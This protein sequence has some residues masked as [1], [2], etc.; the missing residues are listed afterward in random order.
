MNF[1][2]TRGY[3]THVICCNDASCELNILRY[4]VFRNKFITI[5]EYK[6]K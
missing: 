2:E 3:P 6:I 4:D 5:R 1:N